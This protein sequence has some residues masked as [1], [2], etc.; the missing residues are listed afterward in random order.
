MNQMDKLSGFRFAIYSLDTLTLDFAP[1]LWTA[2]V[3]HVT[4]HTDGQLVFLFHNG[5]E[6][7]EALKAEKRS[8]IH[9]KKL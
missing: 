6:I 2:T 5:A 1:T 8:S 9:I 4:A 3:K 7:A